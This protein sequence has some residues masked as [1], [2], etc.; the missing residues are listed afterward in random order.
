MSPFR[1][2]AVSAIIWGGVL[3]GLGDFLFAHVHYGWRLGVFQ[4]VAGGLIGL[5]AARAGGV[6]TYLLGTLLHFLIATG[7]ASLF[8]ILGRRLPALVRH[9]V[10]TGLAYGLVIYVAMNA[11]ILPLSALGAP[12]RLPPLLSAPAAAHLFLVGLPIALAT[13]RASR[14]SGTAGV[15]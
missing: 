12:W 1:C 5:K 10:P 6:P 2:A 7:W 4:S 8:W 11:V 15:T 9:A 14:R 13:S 3:A